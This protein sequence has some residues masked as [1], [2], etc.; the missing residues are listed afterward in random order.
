[1]VRKAAREIV[2]G[3]SK[4]IVINEENVISFLPS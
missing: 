2:S 1:M 3:K 4:Q